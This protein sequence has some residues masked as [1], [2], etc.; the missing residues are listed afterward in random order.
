MI[1]INIKIYKHYTT[2]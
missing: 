1:T 2:Q